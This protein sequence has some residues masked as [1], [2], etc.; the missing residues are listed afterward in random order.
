MT[1][2]FVDDNIR[3]EVLRSGVLIRKCDVEDEHL[4]LIVH[5]SRKYKPLYIKLRRSAD[6]VSKYINKNT[7]SWNHCWSQDP[8]L[9]IFM[10]AKDT[11]SHSH[12]P[13][14]SSSLK[15]ILKHYNFPG[16][17]IE[18]ILPEKREYSIEE[19]RKNFYEQAKRP[20]IEMIY[21]GLMRS[22]SVSSSSSRSN[23]ITNHLT[24]SNSNDAAIG[25]QLNNLKNSSINKKLLKR[26]IEEV[27]GEK[28]ANSIVNQY[29]SLN[30]RDELR[31]FQNF[32]ER[33]FHILDK[34]HL[35]VH[36]NMTRPLSHYYIASS[37]NTYLLENGQMKQITADSTIDG[38]RLALIKGCR[39]IEVDVWDGEEGDPVVTHGRT[40]STDILFREA[41]NTIRK[42]AF[43]KSPYPVIVSMVNHCTPEQQLQKVEKYTLK[44]EILS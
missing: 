28:H 44:T 36:Q 35:Q 11:F 38:Y 43:V 14:K 31:T 9:V 34:K 16:S 10:R 13:L 23:S 12:Q 15:K 24:S 39:F 19:F 1:D 33:N 7:D 41:I 6:S 27:Q 3:A 26:F 29:L 2:D 25:N 21:K 42:Y 4:C 30:N 20:E 40:Q 22:G 37:H 8:A 18:K 17:L 32:M 5:I